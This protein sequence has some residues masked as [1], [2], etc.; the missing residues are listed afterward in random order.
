M[1]RSILILLFCI[2]NSAVFA[3]SVVFNR[4]DVDEYC[5]KQLS[6]LKNK[7]SNFKV[8]NILD[9]L[10]SNTSHS[11]LS[12]KII[13]ECTYEINK[14]IKSNDSLKT[15]KY[16]LDYYYAI[17][18]YC[19]GDSV[20]FVNQID[21]VKSEL[22]KSNR[23]VEY[24]SINVQAGNFFSLYN[25]V[26][27]RFKF[28]L[29]NIKLF[30]KYKNFDWKDFD[31]QNYNS[32]GFLYENIYEYDSAIKY[33][34]IGLKLAEEKNAEV[35]YG[36]MSGNI[37]TIYL[38][39]KKHELAEKFLL[40]DLKTSKKYN[41][42]ESA[43]NVMFD[44]IDIK[45]HQKKYNESL[46]LLD[47]TYKFIRIIDTINN[48]NRTLFTNRLYF[49]KAEIFIGLG[50]LD[51]ARIYYKKANDYLY[52]LNKDLRKKEKTLLN[53][54]YNFEENAAILNKLE[55][56]NKQTIF[57]AVIALLL[58]SSA[59]VILI[60][61][62]RFNKK[63][64]HKSEEL[65]ELNLQK[66]KLF[67]IVSH[68]LKSP[69]NTLHSLL[70]LYNIEAINS[71]D[72]L[73]YKSEINK[74]ITEISD[75]LNNL[76]IWASRSMKSGVKVEKSDVNLSTL[77]NEVISQFSI[78]IK[79]KNLKLTLDNSF[80]DVIS[81]DRNML[82]VV[83]TNLINNAIKFTNE[84]K[85]IL[86]NILPFE[87]NFVKIEIHDQGIGIANDKLDSIFRLGANKSTIG[88]SGEKGTGLGLII[89]SD[90]VKLMGGKINVESTQNVGTIF[91]IILP[92]R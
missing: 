76:L 34:N 14:I 71:N 28:Y 84:N 40:I 56:K 24:A 72:F 58:F 60:I 35:W 22:L 82:F 53:R 43:L 74:T 1:T 39:L 68:D 12:L 51:S 5:L 59:V 25:V 3:D 45:N 87:N 92:T 2:F 47:S 70:D 19:K 65:E 62:S 48:S 11:K 63:I 79:N 80:T 49:T 75:N 32:L 50:N 10:M 9:F 69:L 20:G 27:L 90:F 26:D 13:E 44:L 17:L 91:T 73:K 18:T 42:H 67:S 57:I 37:G 30:N 4:N 86:I 54:R 78:L 85:S 81:V 89:C 38:K 6:E 66:D 61:L 36:L 55:V 41:M 16:F 77:I 83:L 52:T 8:N 23:L 7:P 15:N 29:D 21:K 64:K 33:Y 31:I 88:T 46:V